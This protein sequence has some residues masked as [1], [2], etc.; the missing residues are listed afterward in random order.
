MN[1]EHYQ[2]N[3]HDYPFNVTERRLWRIESIA[4]RKSKPNEVLCLRVEGNMEFNRLLDSIR[5]I[6]GRHYQNH[7]KVV[8]TEDCLS[9][10]LE[11]PDAVPV[12][13]DQMPDTG[14]NG[15]TENHISRFID[16]IYQFEKLYSFDLTQEFPLRIRFFQ[17]QAQNDDYLF[18]TYHPIVMSRR[19]L[20]FAYLTLVQ[21]LNS[22]TDSYG[23]LSASHPDPNNAEHSGKT[24]LGERLSEVPLPQEFPTDRLRDTIKNF[25]SLRHEFVIPAEKA[26]AIAALAN[27]PGDI[28]TGLLAAFGL[29][30][31]RYIQRSTVYVGVVCRSPHTSHNNSQTL[32]DHALIKIS[33]KEKI[34]FTGLTQSVLADLDQF[35]SCGPASQELMITTRPALESMIVSPVNQI[36]FDF[37]DRSDVALPSFKSDITRHFPSEPNSTFSHSDLELKV[38]RNACGTLAC[39]L[40]YAPALFE[41]STAA[42]IVRHFCNLLNNILAEPENDVSQFSLMTANEE[43]SLLSKEGNEPKETVPA[44]ALDELFRSQAMQTPDA[45]ALVEQD[46]H[47]SFGRLNDGAARLA[48]QLASI[49]VSE[50]DRV[51]VLFP[52]SSNFI[53][54]VLAILRCKAIY[55]PLDIAFPLEHIQ[56]IEKDAKLILVL[57][58]DE[59]FDFPNWRSINSFNPDQVEGSSADD[60]YSLT[61]D[62]ARPAYLIY[63]SGSTGKPKGVLGSHQSVV[64]RIQWAVGAFG[65]QDDDIFCMKTSAAFADHIAESF[66]PLL[67]GKPLVIIDEN[68]TRQMAQMVT[69]LRQRRVTRLTLVP[70]IMEILLREPGF[71]GLQG[72][73]SICCSGETLTFGLVR[74]L[75]EILPRTR[76]FNLYGLTEAGADSTCYEVCYHP[77]DNLEDFFKSS[78]KI[79]L[80]Y[81]TQTDSLDSSQSL[82]TAPQISLDELKNGFQDS[83]IPDSGMNVESYFSWLTTSVFPYMVNVSSGRFIGHMTSALPDF[84]RELSATVSQLNQNMVKIETSKSLTLLERQLMA[85]LHRE[86]FDHADYDTQIQDPSCVFGLTVS[87]GSSANITAM[88]NARN[89]SLMALGAS[90]AEIDE[91]GAFDVMQRA[92]YTGFAI[93]TS[94]LAHY[95]I[96][97]AAS[98]LGIGKNGIIVLEQDDRQRA[99]ISDLEKQIAACRERRIL[100]IAVVGIAGTTETGTIDPIA[101]MSRVAARHEIHFHV[102]AAWGG[103][104]IF[105]SKYRKLLN[106]IENA[107]TITLCP[108]KQ[109]YAPQGISLCLFR[110]PHHIHASS[111]HAVYQGQQGSYDVGQYTI[112]G[113]RPAIFLSLHAILHIMSKGG[114][115]NLIEQNIEKTLYFANVI[116]RHD[117][118]ELIGE[119]QINILN[120]RYIPKNLRYKSHFSLE[121][122][123][124]ISRATTTIQERQFLQGKTFVSKTE[125]IN[126][127]YCPRKITVFRVVIANPLTGHADLLANLNNQL[128]I[129][130]TCVESG[131]DTELSTSIYLSKLSCRQ[132]AKIDRYSVPI[133]R[134]IANT[135]VLILDNNGRLMPPGIIGEIH[136]GGTGLSCGYATDIGPNHGFIEH[137]YRPGEK[138]FRT[139]DY[140]RLLADGNIEFCGRRDQQIKIRGMRIELTEVEAYMME[141]EQVN[142]CAV[143]PMQNDDNI[144]LAAFVVPNSFCKSKTPDMVEN[145]IRKQLVASIPLYLIP[146]TILFVDNLP[147]TAGGK[148]D[149]QALLEY[150]RIND[151]AGFSRKESHTEIKL[152]RIWEEILD[153]RPIEIKDNFFNLG[154]HSI[155]AASLQASIKNEFS[156]ELSIQSLFEYPR[157]DDIARKIDE[158]KHA[159]A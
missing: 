108:H 99:R 3:T 145:E 30:V 121:E 82:V 85:M 103:A 120:Y 62:P 20:E 109:L 63:T 110:N 151:D 79:A 132:L 152:K 107:D 143:L 88:W 133:G 84:I 48:A 78:Q 90:K 23:Q 73:R 33:F 45:I 106:G 18:L 154:G 118:F 34:T 156:V 92:G 31:H 27:Q 21:T 144:R 101:E 75:F 89:R 81:A 60:N 134:P 158:E 2:L 36:A 13:R 4:G 95:S 128:E 70:S 10:R 47:I 146:D 111:V 44:K 123:H 87:G 24:L 39:V 51:G 83:R 66:Q 71:A 42:S 50:G 17:G 32:S 54:S 135:E 147:L 140:G 19:G 114:I 40:E 25:E 131:P 8:Q 125:I 97:K 6:A 72:L 7:S 102:D 105:S 38:V 122:N 28:R 16:E 116:A 37:V 59:K 80:P 148:V 129:A 100:I 58:Q 126:E 68:S 64:N 46:N 35:S 137:P 159:S 155:S 93:I 12:G 91:K 43:Q 22:D 119:P 15:D 53:I 94:R 11:P 67:T 29:L 61:G 52:R 130:D 9:W 104:M 76:L 117:A 56:R 139:G 115:G 69:Q 157:L 57:H 150:Y 142:Q 96:T 77:T 14:G 113:S 65:L 149:R 141:L 138:L 41:A 112:E 74:R 86:F 136:I 26:T 5:K 1:I 98:L 153:R 127:R 124:L 49:G 55:V